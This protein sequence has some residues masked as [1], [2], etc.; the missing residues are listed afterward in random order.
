MKIHFKCYKCGNTFEKEEKEVISSQQSFRYCYCGG[1]LE[2]YNL[3]AIVSQDV[4]IQIKNNVDK[5]LKF[6]GLEGT[7]ELVERYTEK[8]IQELYL[9]ELKKRG[10]IRS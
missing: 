9:K 8:G 4:E 5:Y 10:I 7:I 6:Y 1:K 2:I 3:D